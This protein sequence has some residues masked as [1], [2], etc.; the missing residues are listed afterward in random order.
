MQ[1]LIPCCVLFTAHGVQAAAVVVHP[2][3]QRSLLC[4]A[5]LWGGWGGVGWGGKPDQHDASLGSCRLALAVLPVDALFMFVSAS[6]RTR[7]PCLTLPPH[8]LPRT[9][10]S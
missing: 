10:L 6:R 1:Q 5:V 3:P 9:A 4:C 2:P 7:L 8:D